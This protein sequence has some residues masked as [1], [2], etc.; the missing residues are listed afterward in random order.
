[1]SFLSNLGSA[2]SLTDESLVESLPGLWVN[3][4][5]SVVEY[6]N[7]LPSATEAILNVLL[8]PELPAPVILFVL[9]TFLI[10]T[11]SLIL[12]SCGNSVVT[13]TTL[14]ATVQVLINLLF[15]SYP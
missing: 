10:L 9:V 8:Y 1:M 3:P 6:V 14:D 12:R 5:I 7:V 13:V 11:R 4:T 15:L 2:V